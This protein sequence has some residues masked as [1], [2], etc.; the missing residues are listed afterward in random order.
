MPRS[1]VAPDHTKSKPEL[2]RN[3]LRLSVELVPIKRPWRHQRRA[4][5]PVKRGGLNGSMQRWLEVY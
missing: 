5:V 3:L 4:E 1:Y 2:G